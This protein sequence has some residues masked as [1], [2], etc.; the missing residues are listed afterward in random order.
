MANVA[1]SLALAMAE[2]RKRC[3]SD[4]F[5]LAEQL[6]FDFVWETHAELFANYIKYKEDVPWGEQSTNKDVMVLWSRGHYKTTSI[7]VEI[8]QAILNYPNIRILIMQGSLKVTQTLLK[9]V[10]AHF[11]G[12]AE[13]SRLME[14]FPEFC[15]EKEEDGSWKFG[16]KAL[17]ATAAQF[18]TPARTRK[19]L[20]QAT[21]T[22]ASP[23]SVKTGQHYDI[24]FFDDLVND[25]N[26]RNPDQLEKV[27]EDFTLAQALIDPGGYR[28]V[29]GTRYAFGD[30][31][32]QVLR[33]QADSGKWIISI[34]DCWTDESA[35][36]PDEQKIPRFPRYTMRSGQI[37]G[38]TT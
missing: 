3:K 10:V 19:Q 38:F 11:T 24:G 29:T 21:V 18:T 6:G 36:L 25:Q 26:Y 37:G 1:V 35:N 9:Q 34:K 4:K 23:K 20:A 13:G 5:Y 2:A 33:W 17:N 16:K 12:E 15:G 22:V 31:Y 14:L 7:I 32:E 27:R 30:L 8:I 28:F